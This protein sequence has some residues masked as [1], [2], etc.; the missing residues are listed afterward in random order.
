[1]SKL[2]V[3]FCRGNNYLKTFANSI[4][5]SNATTRVDTFKEADFLFFLQWMSLDQVARISLGQAQMVT[6]YMKACIPRLYLKFAS[7]HDLAL[8]QYISL[9]C[10]MR[11]MITIVPAVPS[12]HPFGQRQMTGL[13]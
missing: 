4:K 12:A 8:I 11:L 6:G 7:S 9:V 10:D 13:L 2:C 5:D 3:V 1:M